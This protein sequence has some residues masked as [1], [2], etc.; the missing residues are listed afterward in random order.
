MQHDAHCEFLYHGRMWR[1]A[2]VARGEAIGTWL[3]LVA[4][5][6]TRKVLAPVNVTGVDWQA[7]CDEQAHLLVR[8]FG[9]RS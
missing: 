9:V 7:H 3:F 1:L 4:W 8:R 5:I 6:G 2:K